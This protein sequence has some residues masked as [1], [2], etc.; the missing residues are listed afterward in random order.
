[1]MSDGKTWRFLPIVQTLAWN[2]RPICFK[3]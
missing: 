1:V 3:R 2:A